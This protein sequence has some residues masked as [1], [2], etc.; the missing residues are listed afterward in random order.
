MLLLLAVDSVGEGGVEELMFV[1]SR[2]A[3]MRKRASFRRSS[4]GRRGRAK[5]GQACGLGGP[6]CGCCRLCDGCGRRQKVTTPTHMTQRGIIGVSARFS[7][8]AN[9]RRDR[10][11]MWRS[12]PVPKTAND[13]QQGIAARSKVVTRV[14][15]KMD[16]L[17]NSS[18]V[19]SEREGLDDRAGIREF[20]GGNIDKLQPLE[21]DLA[22]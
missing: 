7:G 13:K 22:S 20:Q 5:G 15:M 12:S 8:S 19:A 14:Y 18:A 1:A 17:W 3:S 9:G 4:F 16:R 6:F 10:K 21:L 2:R 11:V